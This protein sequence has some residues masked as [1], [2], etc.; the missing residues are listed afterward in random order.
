MYVFITGATGF[1]GREILSQLTAAGHRARALVRRGSEQKLAALQSVDVHFGDP[2]ETETL[3]GAL[4][5]CDAVIHL[6]GIIREFP[7]KDIT[8]QKLHVDATRNLI[9]A[10]EAQGVKRFLHMSANGARPDA[11]A[12]YH[13]TKWQAEELLRAS[14]LDWTI[15]RPSLVFGRDGEFVTMLADL[16]RR[17]PVIPIIGNGRYRMQPV[18]IEDLALS[19]VKAL[20]LPET[21]GQTYH[22]GG[23]ESYT[24]EQIIDL[25][26][27]AI[28]KNSVKK[29][30]HPLFMI[31]PAIKMLEG[32]AAFPITSDQ[33][34]MMLEGNVCDPSP[35]AN[36]FGIKPTSY[37]EG[38]GRCLQTSRP[39]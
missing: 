15:F 37:A 39:K 32:V 23:A 33:L 19:V 24:Y 22:V 9:K 36:T 2:A 18:A 27:K 5:G 7:D 38:I 26:G 34:T 14:K 21:I 3:E 35:W 11:K 31:R 20:D 13:Q 1:I 6:V 4:A 10:A 30:R 17:L 28:G 8:F 25:T 16:I 29:L 12:A